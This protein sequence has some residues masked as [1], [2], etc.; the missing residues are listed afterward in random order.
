MTSINNITSAKLLIIINLP[1]LLLIA[2]VSQIG[3]AVIV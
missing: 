3:Y 1:V 2:D